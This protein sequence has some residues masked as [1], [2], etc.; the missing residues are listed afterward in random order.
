MKN[1]PISFADDKVLNDFVMD[2][3]KDYE[4]TDE[5]FKKLTLIAVEILDDVREKYVKWREEKLKV[6][7]LKQF[8][9]EFNASY[10]GGTSTAVIKQY[11]K[12]Q[13]VNTYSP[14]YH[15]ARKLL[16]KALE[17]KVFTNEQLMIAVGLTETRSRV[18]KKAED[19]VSLKDGE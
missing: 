13:G 2:L 19:Y 3:I 1:N 9:E 16:N 8:L 18:R 5:G 15:S 7:P 11:L 10:S 17:T 12:E 14:N 4:V 6:K